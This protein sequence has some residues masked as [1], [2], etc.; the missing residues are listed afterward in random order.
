MRSPR[1]LARGRRISPGR[2]LDDGGD[3][4]D[5]LD[6]QFFFQLCSNGQFEIVARKA[7]IA[8]A[9]RSGVRVRRA[10]ARWSPP[11]VLFAKWTHMGV[12]VG[13]ATAKAGSPA[14]AP[15]NAKWRRCK[16]RELPQ[17]ITRAS[18]A[19]RRITIAH[20]TEVCARRTILLNGRA[21]DALNGGAVE[22]LKI[23]LPPPP[24]AP[25]PAPPRDKTS[26]TGPSRRRPRA[27]A[28]PWP[29]RCPSRC[30][31]PR[32]RR[33]SQF[34]TGRQSPARL[35][36]PPPPGGASQ[37]ATRLVDGRHMRP[38]AGVLTP[39]RGQKTAPMPPPPPPPPAAPPPAS[40]SRGRTSSHDPSSM[41]VY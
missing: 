32:K 39:G 36:L 22:A 26:T 23:L 27:Q 33:S 12:G 37:N 17:K 29:R 41:R 21:A 4:H 2:P 3:T 11:L 25:A 14:R 34:P 18:T 8:G 28:R 20:D 19:A 15:R 30:R 6:R 13:A 16:K 40:R 24:G 1:L 7:K 35:G 9:L 38:G 31:T 10:S 5:G